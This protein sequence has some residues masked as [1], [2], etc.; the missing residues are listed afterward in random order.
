MIPTKALYQNRR[1]RVLD[2]VG[3]GVFRVLD[4]GDTVRVV[5]RS[6]LTLLS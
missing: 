4:P 5:H 1:C 6:R 3:N 2:Y